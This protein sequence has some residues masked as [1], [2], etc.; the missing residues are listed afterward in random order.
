MHR[1]KPTLIG[2]ST[3]Y[4]LARCNLDFG[5]KVTPLIPYK[6]IVLLSH[7]P[8]ENIRVKGDLLFVGHGV[9]A[10]EF[11]LATAKVEEVLAAVETGVISAAEALEAELAGKNRKSLLEP[12][13]ELIAQD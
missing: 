7:K 8:E 2:F 13:E 10:P 3:N 9:E 5:K 1:P 6:E 11:D 12:L 4:K